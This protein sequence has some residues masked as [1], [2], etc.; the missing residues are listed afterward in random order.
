M[1]GARPL[2]GGSGRAFSLEVADPRSA[3][4]QHLG[5]QKPS[6]TRPDASPKRLWAPKTAQDGFLGDLGATRRMLFRRFSFELSATKRQ[7]RN[8]KKESCDLHQPTWLLR[9]AVAP[10]CSYV[11]RNDR[12]TLHVQPFVIAYPQAHLVKIIQKLGSPNRVSV[13]SSLEVR[14]LLPASA[15]SPA[16]SWSSPRRLKKSSPSISWV[17]LSEVKLS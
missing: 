5:V 12:R 17:E 3:L 9:C 11:F 10:C 2:L 15:G 16:H 4:G 13:L 14:L 1:S 8:L 7:N 6:W